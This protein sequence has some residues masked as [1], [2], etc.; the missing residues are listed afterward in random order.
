MAK[1]RLEDVRGE[2]EE[3]GWKM[4][5]DA[6]ENLDAELTLECPE[7]HRVYISL[8][9]FRR[10]PE[11]P[12]CKNNP[13]KE[14][15][16]KV[17]PKNPNI[18]RVLALDQATKLSGWSIYDGT[19]LIKY[20]VYHTSLDDE[21]ARIHAVNEWLISM[22]NNW[23]PDIIGIED[24]QLQD[25]SKTQQTNAEKIG[26][27]TFKVLARLQGALLNTIFAS[28]II[29][30]VVHSSTWRAHCKVTGRTKV[31][32]KR[33]M[34]L[35]VKKWFDISVTDDAADAIGLGKYVADTSVRGMILES[36]E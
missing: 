30:Q 10:N 14:I 22:I 25:F 29:V 26:V 32:K 23:K 7:E 34:Q 24:I 6:Y 20:G 31:D 33:S 27:Q 21:A 2:I 15:D 35:L 12:T 13:F 4:I 1:L 36:W 28:K 5:S 19:Q 8:K 17:I 3:K 11:C 16:T 9:K 18:T